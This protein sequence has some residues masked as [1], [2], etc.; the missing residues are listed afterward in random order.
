MLDDAGIT[1]IPL[2][3]TKEDSKVDS[4]VD[5]VGGMKDSLSDYKTDG[6]SSSIG[7][8]EYNKN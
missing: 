4:D 1:T 8:R 3:R 6:L 2:D 7:F 5:S